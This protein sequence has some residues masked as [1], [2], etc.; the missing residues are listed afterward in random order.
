VAGFFAVT[1]AK[2]NLPCLVPPVKFCSDN[3]LM[4]AWTGV[5]RLKLGLC[6]WAAAASAAAPPGLCTGFKLLCAC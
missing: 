2:Y 5:E 3:G 6:R 4:V 1:L